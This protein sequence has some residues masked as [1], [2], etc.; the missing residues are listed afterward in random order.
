MHSIKP[1]RC[2][3]GLFAAN[4][5]LFHP[6]PVTLVRR[7]HSRSTKSLAPPRQV[8]KKVVLDLEPP[9]LEL[10]SGLSSKKFIY[11]KAGGALS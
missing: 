7:N 1:L 4:W 8:A 2:K 6:I 10:R 5:A 11:G 9:T 3:L